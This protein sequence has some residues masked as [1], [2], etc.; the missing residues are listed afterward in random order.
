VPSPPDIII[1]VPG[2]W[3]TDR[4]V[5]L[6][7]AKKSGGYLFA[8]TVLLEIETKQSFVIER[9]PHDPRMQQSF[10]VA[11]AGRIPQ[12][13]LDAIG[14]HTRVLY[15]I[16]PGGSAV[17]TRAMMRAACGLL[18]AGGLAVKVESSGLGHPAEE[19]TRM[20][21]LGTPR[22]LHRAFVVQLDG[23]DKLTTCG[24]HNFGLRDAIFA[25]SDCERD[26]ASSLLLQFQRYMLAEDPKLNHGHTFSIAPDA[27]W[28]RMLAEDCTTYPPGDPFHNPY[29]MWRLVRVER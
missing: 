8:G 29:G 15:L 21:E 16:G 22:D 23:V 1:C 18:R 26:E 4:D 27:P 2:L 9:E 20:T 3:P 12:S 5:V 28:Y 11:G 7:I 24:M 25:D 14:R 17:A 13:V 10:R 19:W 6:D